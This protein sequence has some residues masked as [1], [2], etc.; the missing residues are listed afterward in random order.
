MLQSKLYK[1]LASLEKYFIN[2]ASGKRKVREIRPESASMANPETLSQAIAESSSTP[3]KS[4]KIKEENEGKRKRL[5]EEFEMRL[6][7]ESK[8]VEYKSKKSFEGEDAKRFKS[9][10]EKSRTQVVEEVEIYDCSQDHS[11]IGEIKA[12]S[13]GKELLPDKLCLNITNIEK[14]E[15]IFSNSIFS[16]EGTAREKEYEQYMENNVLKQLDNILGKGE[17]CFELGD[18]LDFP[19][20]ESSKKRRKRADRLKKNE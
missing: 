3:N 12:S 5:D 14:D 8:E 16:N 19:L 11:H 6:E 17:N 9:I 15:T 20:N 18:C 13:E 2:P 7:N 10:K 4:R 1:H